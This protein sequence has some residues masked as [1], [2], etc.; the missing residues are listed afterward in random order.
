MP[1]RQ[2]T[3]KG[4]VQVTRTSAVVTRVLLTIAEPMPLW[5]GFC[6]SLSCMTLSRCCVVEIFKSQ[7]RSKTDTI[8]F[9]IHARA[10]RVLEDSGGRASS[11]YFAVC[12]ESPL[13]AACVVTPCMQRHITTPSPPLVSAGAVPATP[14]ATCRETGTAPCW[15]PRLRHSCHRCGGAV[16]A[17]CF[18]EAGAAL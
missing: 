10:R 7:K 12:N 9:L 18:R 5:Q 1:L 15:A 14:A 8:S 3:G 6:S 17:G 13:Y 11:R 2:L 16:A 4:S